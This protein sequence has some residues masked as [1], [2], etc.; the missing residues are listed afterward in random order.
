M[1]IAADFGVG[2]AV[3]MARRTHGVGGNC[4]GKCWSRMEITRTSDLWVNIAVEIHNICS[5][6][7]A[8]NVFLL[9]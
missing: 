9:I 4:G 7:A 3:D 5:S 1:D 6:L 8:D 2:I